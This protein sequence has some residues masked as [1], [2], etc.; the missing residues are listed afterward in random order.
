MPERPVNPRELGFYVSLAQVGLE[1]VAPVGLGA[2]LDASFG[3]TPWATVIGFALGFIGGFLHLL[4]LLKR[5]E[6]AERRKP[7]GQQP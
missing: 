2:I 5:H 1:M 7:P 3:W 4:V 6:E